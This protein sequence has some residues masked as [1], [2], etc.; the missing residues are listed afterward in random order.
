MRIRKRTLARTRS[1]P[2]K[3][4]IL[5]AYCKYLVNASH[6]PLPTPHSPLP[7]PITHYPLP[8][9]KRSNSFF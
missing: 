2:I 9:F 6:S 4:C 8:N 3:A 5:L 7:I 1:V